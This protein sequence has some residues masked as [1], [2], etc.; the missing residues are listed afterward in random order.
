MDDY[1]ANSKAQL[2][3]EDD[4]ATKTPS[5]IPLI[6]AG[7]FAAATI[8]LTA[9]TV[10]FVL[11]KNNIANELD[12]LKATSKPTQPVPLCTTKQCYDSAYVYLSSMD[13]SKN[14]CENFFEYACGG[15]M[16]RYTVPDDQTSISAF[17]LLRDD[18]TDKLKALFEQSP[19]AG[20][21]DSFHI[22]RNDYQ[23][24]ED[25][26]TINELGA[27]PLTDLLTSLG[28]WPVLGDNPAGGNWDQAAFDFEKLW[29]DIKGK[30]GVEMIVASDVYPDPDNRAKYKLDAYTPNFLVPRTEIEN[31]HLR[32]VKTLID[33]RNDPEDYGVKILLE[34]KYSKERQAY[35]QY[36]IDIAVA[37]GASEAVATQDMTDLIEFESAMANLTVEHPDTF[38]GW[39]GVTLKEIGM[40]EIDWVRFYNLML[41]ASVN[42]RV[43]DNEPIVNYNPNYISNVTMWLKDQSKRV[44]A[45]YMI[46]RLVSQMVP[47]MNETF[48]AIRQKY[49]ESVY[50]AISPTTRWKTCVSNA[51]DQYEF[52]SGRMYVDEHFPEDA[53]QKTLDMIRNLQT[54]FKSMLTTNDWL[55]EED[56]PKAAR[57]ADAMVI[58]IGY[59]EWIKD[60]AKLDA[61]YADLTAKNKEYFQNRLRYREWISQAELALLRED[62]EIENSLVSGSYPPTTF[63]P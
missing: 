45:N 56:K 3:L 58:E 57:K 6:L 55:Q 4:V 12:E 54:A 36:L 23:S 38:L 41:P 42:P 22:V 40:D 24:C 26:D 18:L 48:L 61:E 5:R 34:E 25:M 52:I 31:K 1:P 7:I 59:P 14:P 27:K 20:E 8:A 2:A 60:N 33:E 16:E 9:T 44:K 50:G 13:P 46:W 37:L 30:Y 10:V 62:V 32:G 11:Q 15:W 17:T 35:F 51:K 21:P 63:L 28:G 29:A 19:T 43:T 53:K 49:L 39:V 47:F